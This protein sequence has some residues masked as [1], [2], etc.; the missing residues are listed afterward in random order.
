[1]STPH[2]EKTASLIERSLH[3]MTVSRRIKQK[4]VIKTSALFVQ[5]VELDRRQ[6]DWKIGLKK[7]YLFHIIQ[8]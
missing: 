7:K 5:T 2:L 6:Q 1:V 3:M 8:C 4:T